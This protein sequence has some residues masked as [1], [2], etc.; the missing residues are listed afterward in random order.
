[1]KAFLF[2]LSSL[3]AATA[4]ADGLPTTPYIYVQGAAEER[5]APDVLRVTFQAKAGDKDV[6]RAKAAVSDKSAAIFKVLAGLGIKDDAIVAPALSVTEDYD[7][8]KSTGRELRGYT[9]DRSFTVRLTDFALYPR[10]VNELIELRVEGLDNPQLAY[11]K[12][13][14]RSVA[15]KQAAMTQARKEAEDLVTSTGARITGVFAVSP[16][17]F[18]EIPQAIFGGSGPR[19][20]PLAYEARAGKGSAGDKYLFDEITLSERLHVIFLVEPAGK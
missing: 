16:I 17:A 3:L 2:L 9:V 13:A 10:L 8:T 7:Y 6:A 14:E 15:L 18:G 11:S 12:A 20:M 5:V 4:F 19:P 1:M